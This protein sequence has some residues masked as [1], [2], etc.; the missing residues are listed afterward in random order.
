M[1]EKFMKLFGLVLEIQRKLD[2]LT[3]EYEKKI[4]LTKGLASNGM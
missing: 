4:P 2:L 3:L 1:N